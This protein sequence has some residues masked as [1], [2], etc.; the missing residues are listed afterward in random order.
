MFAEARSDYVKLVLIS[1]F[2]PTGRT[3][4]DAANQ[5]KYLLDFRCTRT[6][7][8]GTHSRRVVVVIVLHLRARRRGRVSPGKK[9]MGGIFDVSSD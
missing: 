9:P 7:D 4:C 8:R 6:G 3:S 2:P 5:C 1:H